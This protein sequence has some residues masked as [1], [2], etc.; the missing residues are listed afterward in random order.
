[1]TISFVLHHIHLHHNN[2][3]CIK[4]GVA[5]IGQRSE[6]S[7]SSSVWL[8]NS[9]FPSYFS[10]YLE[11]L[12][13]EDACAH[14]RVKCMRP[15]KLFL[16]YLFAT[17][18]RN[19]IKYLTV[20]LWLRTKVWYNT[21]WYMIS[22]ARTRY[23]YILV[24]YSSAVIICSA[25]IIQIV[26][27][28]STISITL[29]ISSLTLRTTFTYTRYNGAAVISK[30]IRI[31]YNR[32]LKPRASSTSTDIVSRQSTYIVVRRQSMDNVRRLSENNVV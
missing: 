17:K 4:N 27:N 31:E 11:F 26:E 3:I 30:I 24:R 29:N 22:V 2:N 13:D 23:S 32:N 19:K 16:R 5:I 9:F 8:F 1:M 14:R 18:T 15:Y 12:G 21:I 7:L 20:I 25:I 6:K 28:T 10:F